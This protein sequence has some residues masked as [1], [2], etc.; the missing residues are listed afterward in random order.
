[1][2]MEIH[3]PSLNWEDEPMVITPQID[4]LQSADD[5]QGVMNIKYEIERN[6]NYGNN[7]YVNMNNDMVVFRYADILY[8]KAE[9]LM[10]LNG[11]N[12]TQDAVGLV[13]QVRK[14]NF[15]ASDFNKEKY[16]VATLTLDELLNERGREFAYEMFRREDMIRFGK[17]QDAWWEKEQENDKHNE[18]FPIPFNVITANPALKQNP[19][20]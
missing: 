5:N 20:Y 10:R 4:D 1:M 14:R 19:G 15:S 9:C 17:F 13:N 3:N 6:L 8:M 12:A 7:G 18:I 2:Q 11:G 16:T